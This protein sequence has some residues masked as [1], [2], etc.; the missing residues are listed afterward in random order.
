MWHEIYQHGYNIYEK[1]QQNLKRLTLL[2]KMMMILN[3][4][5]RLFCI[6]S[7]RQ[8]YI[9]LLLPLHNHKLNYEITIIPSTGRKET[10]FQAEVFVKLQIA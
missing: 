8:Y 6:I 1:I 9:I 3:R 10:V 4:K 2:Q 7:E 5:F